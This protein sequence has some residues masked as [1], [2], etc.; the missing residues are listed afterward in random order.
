MTPL[1]LPSRAKES[2]RKINE[3]IAKVCKNENKSIE[4][5]NAGGRRREASRVREKIVLGLVKTQGVSLAE[6]ARQL[7]VLTPEVSKIIK[8]ANQQVNS[9]NDLVP[10]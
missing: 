8:R 3:F 7:E 2:P 6:V 9:D 10:S 5:L 1:C 4:K